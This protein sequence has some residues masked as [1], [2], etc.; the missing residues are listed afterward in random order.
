MKIVGVNATYNVGS[1]GTIM[2]DIHNL[3]LDNGYESY[4]A[5]STA[6]LKESEIKNGYKIGGVFGKKV[7]A[8][9]SRIGGKQGYYSSFAT[10]KFIKWL[11][12][13]KPD[14]VHLHNLHSNYINLNML[15]SFL[16]KENIKTF[17]SLHDC[18]FYTGGCFHYTAVGCDRWKTSC[19]NCKARNIG[20][21]S[22]L[23][24]NSKK[25][26]KDRKKYLSAIKDL[27]FVGVSDWITNEA[28]LSG[29][30]AK[31]F[32]TVY[33]G[34]DTDFF[35]P[36]ND[37]FKEELGLK[38][39]F[40]VLGIANKWLKPVNRELLAEFTASLKEDMAFVI[41]GV[42]NSD[43]AL[44][45]KNVITLPFMDR[46]KLRRTYNM[47]DVF[48]NC[49]REESFSLVNAEAG[50][51]GTPVITYANTGAKETVSDEFGFK[52][53]NGN[54]KE[55]IDAVFTVYNTGKEKYTRGA[56]QFVIDNFDK[57]KN[58]KRLIDLYE[59][60]DGN[61]GKE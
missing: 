7:H 40:V 31:Q 42:T 2:A 10:R 16:A 3:L 34:V 29:I 37:T 53:E 50:S 33:N 28:K 58:Y 25:I 54:I 55:F 47:A 38:G 41:M 51:S 14:V 36:S 15:L 23:F 13:L 6:S 32:V 22:Y 21:K 1:T 35:K 48:A 19:K 43:K 45:P 18:W 59:G 17:V 52:V 12:E 30:P 4:V 39:K 20:T 27:T 9:L 57:N 5:Y 44:L 8:L 46:E 11:K 56:R 24:D 49:T 60:G 26:Q 61:N